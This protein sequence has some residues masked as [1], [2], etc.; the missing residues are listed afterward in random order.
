MES[1]LASLVD[2]SL[3]T[4]DPFRPDPRYSLLETMRQYALEQAAAA[5]EPDLR[6][7]LA[8]WLA[9]A[10]EAAHAAF[11]T[12]EERAWTA[13][14]A[15]E[16]DNLRLALGWAFTDGDAALGV[17]LAG[18]GPP[19]WEAQVQTGEQAR[20]IELALA[21][22]GPETP[23][24]NAARLW[25]ARAQWHTLGDQRP[26]AAAQR[27][28]ALFREAGD[29]GGEAEAQLLAAFSLLS[30]PETAAKAVQH[31]DAAAA[32]LGSR[33]LGR[34]AATLHRLRGIALWFDGQRDA[35]W[36][37]FARA[38]TICHD[39]GDISLRL[40]VA[41]SQAQRLF[42]EHRTDEAERGVAEALAAV[43]HSFARS[44]AAIHVSG[45]RA[46]Y[47][48]ALGRLHEGAHAARDALRAA[49]TRG[50]RE[51]L[52]WG[53]E[54]CAAVGLDTA[55]EE[56][57]RLLGY[58]DATYAALGRQ[59][60]EGTATRYTALQQR[61]RERIASDRVA[62]LQAEGATW[63]AETAVRHALVLADTIVAAS[64]RGD[65]V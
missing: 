32:N 33:P 49:W 11:D 52:P 27:A 26:L 65:T 37:E 57:A 46:T 19:L 43:P 2:R 18:L 22:V 42:A 8:A 41:G 36:L 3:L 25:L 10:L 35:A 14:Y 40:R 12:M 54:R 6:P 7:R 17:R 5:A 24:R 53:L 62:A 59:R 4:V 29:A 31:L 1:Q 44:A 9:T 13:R 60:L 61:L 16:V 47:L 30:G 55:P 34:R 48:I 38:T 23:P 51:E 45:L 15:P 56:A 21:R 50:L 20:W 39:I 64:P 58:N 63:T 28:A